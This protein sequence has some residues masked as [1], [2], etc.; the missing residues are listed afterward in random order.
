MREM[1]N[2]RAIVV[3]GRIAHDNAVRVSGGRL[4]D[5]R[6]AHLAEHRLPDG[7]VL[8]DSYHCSRY[9][10]NTGRLDGA[11]F[12]SVF[13]RALQLQSRSH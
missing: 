7:R 10:Q 1:P 4:A 6:F 3:L 9:N 11:M 8:I 5:H 12:E 2:L 13:E